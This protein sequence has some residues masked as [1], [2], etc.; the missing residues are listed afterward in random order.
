MH[1]R[2]IANVTRKYLQKKTFLSV[3]FSVHWLLSRSRFDPV[4]NF[5]KFL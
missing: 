1:N 2:V 4:E 5:L 3:L